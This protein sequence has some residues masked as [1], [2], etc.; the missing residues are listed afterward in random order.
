MNALYLFLPAIIALGLITSYEDVRCGKIR[1]K[2]LLI[3]L[4]Y[5]AIALVIT[6]VLNASSWKGYLLVTAT[7]ALISLVAGFLLWNYGIW[8]AG[9]AKL[10]FV[11][12]LLMPIRAYKA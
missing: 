5:F 9:D 10:F 3:S 1:N 11:F 7:N 4:T 8:S 12:N 6:L 2:W